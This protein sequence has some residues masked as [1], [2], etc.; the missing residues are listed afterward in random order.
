MLGPL[1]RLHR[2]VLVALLLVLG[3]LT[4]L[5]VAVDTPAL[6]L[7]LGMLAGAGA[8][9][10]LALVLDGTQPDVQSG[11]QPAHVLRHPRWRH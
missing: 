3:A 6:P 10:L 1:P 7:S 4:G 11:V 8:G 5:F 2:S 9:A